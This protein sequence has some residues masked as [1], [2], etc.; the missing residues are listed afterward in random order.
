MVT[1]VRA[2]L[3]TYF[4]WNRAVPALHAALPGASQK[5]SC[6]RHSSVG[7]LAPPR[8]QCISTFLIPTMFP[9]RKDSP[10]GYESTRA[11]Y[12]HTPQ[13]LRI[14]PSGVNY[15]GWTSRLLGSTCWTVP[16]VLALLFTAVSE[17]VLIVLIVEVISLGAAPA[18]LPGGE[19]V[20]MLK[21]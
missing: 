4:Y 8:N 7:D 9:K 13:L 17:K 5:T 6:A 1:R 20:R 16:C 21:P 12:I 3:L 15:T 19:V 2:T 10:H 14:Q 11:T 18:I